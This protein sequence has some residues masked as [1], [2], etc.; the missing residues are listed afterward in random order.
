MRKDEARNLRFDNIIHT[1]MGEAGVDQ[2]PGRGWST[3]P[4]TYSCD[5]GSGLGTGW[6]VSSIIFIHERKA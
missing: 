3:K 6:N 5:S 2:V 1:Q 4:P